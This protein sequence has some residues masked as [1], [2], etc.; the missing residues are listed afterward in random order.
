MIAFQ[1]FHFT[2][3]GVSIPSDQFP[4]SS[5]AY[6]MFLHYIVSYTKIRKQPYPF[7]YFQI[8][9]KNSLN[10]TSSRIK[11]LPLP[12]SAWTT[13]KKNN[14]NSTISHELYVLYWFATTI[15]LSSLLAFTFL[16]S[17]FLPHCQFTSS[18]NFPVSL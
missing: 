7:S 1:L 4:Q 14:K 11:I 15:L 13:L 6:K 16:S 12:F 18:P 8:E 5:Q 17:Y 2:M 10:S 9:G 3:V